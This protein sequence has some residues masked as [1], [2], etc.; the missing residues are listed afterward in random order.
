[1]IALTERQ[2]EI[3]KSLRDKASH[4]DSKILNDVIVGKLDIGDIQ[5]AC[6]LVN[7]EYLLKGIDEDYSPNSYGKELN[8]LLN[9]VNE[10]RLS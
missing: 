5:R 7:D 6:E 8:A 10:P 4:R 1:M 9:R 2:T 3:L